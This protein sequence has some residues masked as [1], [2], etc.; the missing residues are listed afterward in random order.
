MKR[1]SLVIL[2]LVLLLSSILLVAPAASAADPVM[3]VFY[4]EV[5]G[6]IRHAELNASWD[7]LVNGDGTQVY[8]DGEVEYAILIQSR[9][10]YTWVNNVRSEF[11]FDT[12]ELQGHKIVSATFMVY[13]VQK[14]DTFAYPGIKPDINLYGANP[15]SYDAISLS[16]YEDMGSIPFS[17]AIAYDDLVVG[18]YNTFDLNW[19]GR[20]AIGDY[21]CLA[22][23]NECYD[24]SG[25][26]P[27]WSGSKLAGLKINYSESATNQPMLVVWYK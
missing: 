22:L 18:D 4:P 15:D 16:D 26:E 14:N 8:A 24:V 6:V 27:T 1:V 9:L 19:L 21:T 20:R 12:S 2:T 7:D 5:D 11:I 10:S 23:R 25:I 17:S 13:G 3:A